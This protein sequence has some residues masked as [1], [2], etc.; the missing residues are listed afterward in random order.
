MEFQFEEW[1]SLAK[2]DPAAFEA[3][4]QETIL[5]FLRE[6][7]VRHGLLGKRLQREIDSRR[8]QA[9]TPQKAFE[10]IAKMMW[11]QLA[12]LSEGLDDLSAYVRKCEGSARRRP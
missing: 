7:S 3:R 9:G 11:E 6:S 8:R 12:F 10:V 2:L 1:A 4:R 5:Q